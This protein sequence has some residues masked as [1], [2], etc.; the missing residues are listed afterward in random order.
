[1]DEFEQMMDNVRWMLVDTMKHV[2]AIVGVYAVA[3]G[4][5]WLLV[6]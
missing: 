6:G 1:M 2:G 3:V 5:W 4:S